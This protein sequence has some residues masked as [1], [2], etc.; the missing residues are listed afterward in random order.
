MPEWFN[1]LADVPVIL[2]GMTAFFA[3]LMWV[4]K[5]EVTAVKHEVYPNSGKSLRDTVDRIEHKLDRH[6]EWH[7]SKE[8]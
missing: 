8:E 5:R 2:T 1:D 3:G 4:I 6:I 7:L